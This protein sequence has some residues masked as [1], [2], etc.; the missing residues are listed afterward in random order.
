MSDEKKVIEIVAQNMK[1]QSE[2]VYDLVRL[3]IQMDPNRSSNEACL[4]AN[5]MSHAFELI[6]A[7]L[8][9]KGG[10]GDEILRLIDNREG[11]R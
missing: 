4:I 2:A 1:T 8:D 11:S 9:G 3:L 5:R 10:V 6:V 7:A